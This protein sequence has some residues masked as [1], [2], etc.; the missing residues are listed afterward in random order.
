MY[1]PILSLH[2][3]EKQSKPSPRKRERERPQSTKPRLTAFC[4]EAA[5]AFS[6][7][8]LPLK[9][10]VNHFDT[11]TSGRP[12]A[13]ALPVPNSKT[14]MAPLFVRANAY[15]TPAIALPHSPAASRLYL[16]SRLRFTQFPAHSLC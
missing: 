3:P 2:Y 8:P 10:Q 16:K 5:A 9:I 7:C 4:R 12:V 13:H 14:S 1:I 6:T 15:E 11:V